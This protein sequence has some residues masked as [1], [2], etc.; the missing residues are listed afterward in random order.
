MAAN[1]SKEDFKNVICAMLLLIWWILLFSSY[2]IYPYWMKILAR[3]KQLSHNYLS[4][5]ENDDLPSVAIMMPLHNEEKVLR[6]KLESIFRSNYDLTKIKVYLGLDNCSDNSLQIVQDFQN[7]YPD[8]ILYIE[9]ERIGKPQM[10]NLLMQEFSHQEEISIF[11]DANVFL[12]KD[13]L[14]ELVKYFK[15]EEIGLVDSRFV[16]S[17]DIVINEMESDYIG[18]EQAL[19]YNEGVAWGT[20]QGPFGGCFAIRTQLYHPIPENFLVDDFFISM[21]VMLQARDAVTNPKARVIEEVYT[22]WNDEYQRKKRISVGNYQNLFYF[23]KKINKP[24]TKLTVSWFFH[25]VLRWTLPILFIP[26]LILSG[27]EIFVLKEPYCLFAITLS[28]ILG[29]VVLL[30]FLQRLNLQ[31]KTIERLSYFIYMNLAL[32]QGFIVYLKGVKSNVWKPT[33]RE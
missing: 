22:N 6:K 8:N 16:L 20:M 4:Y 29:V 17:E 7:K 3:K 32:V 12:L 28:L 15:S 26:V 31:N 11:T 21:A 1:I 27:L 18:F 10:L 33:R 13:T 5:E 14:Y 23:I 24:F 2:F 9:N 30:Y 25:K 19:K